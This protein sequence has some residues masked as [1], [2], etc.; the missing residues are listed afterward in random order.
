[1]EAVVAYLHDVVEDSAVTLQDLTDLGFDGYVVHAVDALTRRDGEVY[2]DY[3]QRV[4]ESDE[5]AAA[6]KVA[7]LTDNM[8]RTD[9]PEKLVSLRPRYEKALMFLS[10]RMV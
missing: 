4:A 7:D 10:G 5:T 2:A 1:V 6:V 9:N 8:E 3:I